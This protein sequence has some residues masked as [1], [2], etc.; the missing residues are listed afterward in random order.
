MPT[1][2]KVST[3]SLREEL[4]SLTEHANQQ[5]AAMLNPGVDNVLGLRIPEV[6][7]LARTI[8]ADVQWKQRLHTLKYQYME[9]RMLH[10]MILGYAKDLTLHNRLEMLARFVPMINSWSVC[11]AV[12]AT[13]TF[14]KEHQVQVW[15]FIQPYL[16]SVNEY[17]VRFALVMML[18]Y[19][20]TPAYLDRL[21]HVANTI[22]HEG[23]Y[24]RMA[25]AWLVSACY[26]KYP[27]ETECFLQHNSLDTFTHNKALQKIRESY[28]V[29]AAD[30]ERLL[31][32]RRASR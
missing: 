18:D 14:A 10:G 21:F 32:Y 22:R 31:H 2:R 30:K 26:V 8:V 16:N 13:L 20:L 19:Y 11:D 6:R 15:E 25:V 9:E 4:L 28:R 27:Q 17:E 1:L 3:Y 12:C 29:S 23:Y 24:V 7:K 5:F